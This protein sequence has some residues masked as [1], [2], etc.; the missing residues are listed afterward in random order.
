MIVA[1][2]VD[3]GF[4]IIPDEI[5][6]GG[7]V[8]GLAFSVI[9]P[10]LHNASLWYVGF[11]NS[12]AGLLIGGLLI[13]FI[14]I[15]GKFIFK[16]E[17]MGGGDVKLLAMIGAFLGPKFTVLIF[18]MAPFFGSIVGIIMKIRY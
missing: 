7:M 17:A 9:H 6:Y 10:Q 11:F 16:K 8:L 13:Y 5:S 1:A 18:F 14:G 4:Q 15:V 3:F 12:A 2:F